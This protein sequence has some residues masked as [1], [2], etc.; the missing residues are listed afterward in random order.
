MSVPL[1]RIAS[2]MR[3]LLRGLTRF[4]VFCHFHVPLLDVLGVTA[5]QSTPRGA[6]TSITRPMMSQASS[7]STCLNS[8]FSGVRYSRPAS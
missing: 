3:L 1:I 6:F 5:A 7:I 8:L 2:T 4:F